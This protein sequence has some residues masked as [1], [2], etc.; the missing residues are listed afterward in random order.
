MKNIKASLLL[1]ATALVI[2]FHQ[3]A[4]A[5]TVLRQSVFGNGGTASSNGAYRLSGTAGQ[6]V[7]GVTS[8]LSYSG[9]QGF[10]YSI[11]NTGIPT[12]NRPPYVVNPIPDQTLTV[13]ASFV[14]DL[15]VAPSVF[16]DL[17]GDVLSYSATSSD[18]SKA[19]ATVSGSTLTIAGVAQS[20]A[21]I[22]VTANDGKGGTA[23]TTFVATVNPPLNRTPVVAN[24]IPNQTLTVGG[25]PFV[26]DLNAVPI[27]FSD[28]DG[29]MLSYSTTSSDPS[30]AAAT[31]SGSVLTVAPVAAGSATITVTANDGKG[32]TV[33]TTF[34]VTVSKPNQ[35]PVVA[36]AI[37]NQT[38]TVGSAAFVRDLNAVPIAFSDPDGDV[39]SYSATS[40]D[41]SKATATI[42]GNVLT[43]APV[44]SGTATIAITA[45]DGKGGTAQTTFVATVNHPPNRP[46]VVA[47]AIPNQTLTAGGAF[48]RNLNAAPVVFSDPD[49]DL[50]SYSATSS[51][52][53]KATATIS[54]STL[55]VSAVAAGSATITVTAT[56]GKGGTV[57]TVFVAT[58]NPRSAY[59]VTATPSSVGPGAQ[60]SV[61]WTA[62]LGSSSKDWIGLYRVGAASNGHLWWRYTDGATSGSFLKN[63]P[64]DPGQYEFRYLLN[65]G[66]TEAARSNVVTVTGP[67][68]TV[69]VTPG[70]IAPGGQ[71]TVRWTAPSGSSPKDW[72]GLYQVGA[73]N[74]GHKWW[75]YTNG[76]TIS[77][78]PYTAPMQPGQYEFRYML[79]DGFTEAGRSNVVTVTASS[80]SVS[81][82]PST[83]TAGGQLTINWTAA[84]G[85]STKDWVG[86]YRVGAPNNGHI[87]W[88]YTQSATSGSITTNA[89]AQ[90]EQYEF[91]Y[92]LN[93]GFTDVARSNVVTVTGGLAKA[94]AEQEG[95]SLPTSFELEQNYPNPFNPETTI[96]Y[97]IPGNVSGS[98]RVTLRIYNLQGQ[99]VRTLV[100]EQKSPGRYRA[101][102]DGK[103]DLGSR[104]ATGVYLYT[105]TAGDFKATKR[106]TVLK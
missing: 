21:T 98:V 2:F 43:V 71:L 77:S 89:P 78:F 44:A 17:D 90:A 99:V 8:S 15:N 97:A 10:W 41:P 48:V 4:Q 23:Q 91:R 54:G 68:Y 103:N 83:I 57:Q 74:N 61:S 13:G 49:A 72:I 81:V 16:S 50:L 87:W 53:S 85:H 1:I 19:T 64:T 101:V 88:Q 82:T 56:D 62:P 55:I 104:T 24:A 3:Q 7:I 70:S 22:T 93:D 32:G 106:M 94:D 80:Y 52:P 42:S 31:V 86:L 12:E 79:N 38:L 35:P 60:V 20:S 26:R 39:L 73:P 27:V 36:N 66:F 45:N 18:P 100:D 34:T 46:P 84:S 102:W 40:S 95:E 63:L 59:T 9:K 6:P 29:D 25:N 96:Q 30:K 58:I 33:S 69:T 65:D 47:N 76:A 37:P 5:Q 11:S 67:A 51:D 92:L 75:T 28:P 14:R 105:I